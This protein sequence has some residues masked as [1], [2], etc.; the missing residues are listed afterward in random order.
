MRIL[1]LGTTKEPHVVFE[2]D[3]PLSQQQVISLLLFNKSVQELNEEEASSSASL[4]QA[5][6]DGAFGLF[7]LVFLSSTPIES[8]GYDPVSGVYSVRMRVDGKTTVSVASDLEGDRQYAIRRRIGKRWAIRTELQ[9][10]EHQ[11]NTA[12]LT[13]LEWFNRF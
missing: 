5:L 6:A 8:V 12:L 2:S 7:S 10:N 13:L 1:I 4:S 11:G 3:P 9:R